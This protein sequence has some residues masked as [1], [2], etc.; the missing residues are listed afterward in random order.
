MPP[1]VSLGESRVI[2]IIVIV[3]IV[4]AI[5]VVIV[6]VI[7]IIISSNNAGVPLGFPRR[8]TKRVACAATAG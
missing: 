6:I 1:P 8:N 3:I 7:V 5:V 4:I 2:V